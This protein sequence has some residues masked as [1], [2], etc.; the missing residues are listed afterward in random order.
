MYNRSLPSGNKI[1]EEYTNFTKSYLYI[2]FTYINGF[3]SMTVF[4]RSEILIQSGRREGSK[5]LISKYKIHKK[6]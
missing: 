4:K 6:P 2:W 5:T 3:Y 1:Y